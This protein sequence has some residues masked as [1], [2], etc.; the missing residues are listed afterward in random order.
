MT[1]KLE[2]TVPEGLRRS[3]DRMKSEEPSD[4]AG[5]TTTH[6]DNTFKEVTGSFEG[7][8]YGVHIGKKF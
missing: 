1:F 7:L 3:L 5:V 4:P 2:N 8:P 6:N